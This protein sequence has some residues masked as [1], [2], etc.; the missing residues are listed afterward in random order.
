MP[1]KLPEPWTTRSRTE[2]Y[3]ARPWLRL[4]GDDVELPDG[5]AVHEF[6][7]IDMPDHAIIVALTDENRVV[8][9]RNYKHGPRRVC[10]N[11]PAGY[12]EPDE[13]PLDAARRE[14]LEETGYVADEWS[15]LGAFVEDGNR[16]CGQAHIYLAQGARQVADPA[17]GD[18]EEMVIDLL[19]LPELFQAT[20]RGETPVLGIVA[21]LGLAM[22][23]LSRGSG[24]S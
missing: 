10:I 12:I 3:D 7:S 22:E 11:L 5:R 18:L 19:T 17:S 13:D 21:A 2:L 24:S 1:G 9:E 16:G 14:L 23:A 20:R 4:Y 15:S 8:V 6:Y